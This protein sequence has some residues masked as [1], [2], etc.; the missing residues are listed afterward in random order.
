VGFQAPPRDLR[1]AYQKENT[2]EKGG[3]LAW[4]RTMTTK[5]PPLETI[6]SFIDGLLR[7]SL[8]I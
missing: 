5:P 4:V 1:G 2:G 7:T 8:T 3:C 6:F